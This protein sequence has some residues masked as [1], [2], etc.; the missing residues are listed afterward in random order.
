MVLD[1]GQSQLPFASTRPGRLYRRSPLLFLPI[2][3]KSLRRRLSRQRGFQAEKASN[4]I[5]LF[6]GPC[7]YLL[8]DSH[9]LSFRVYLGERGLVKAHHIP[10]GSR[11]PSLP[12]CVGQKPNAI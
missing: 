4:G 11:L 3:D 10:H 8:G 9:F 12:V 5:H 2:R 7:R 6:T 1:L